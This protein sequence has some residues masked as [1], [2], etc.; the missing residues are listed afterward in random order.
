VL[1]L[2]FLAPDRYRA[3]RALQLAGAV[4]GGEADGDGSDAEAALAEM[5]ANSQEMIDEC[6][7]ALEYLQRYD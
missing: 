1:S 7:P 3:R 4:P 6:L 5:E 2:S